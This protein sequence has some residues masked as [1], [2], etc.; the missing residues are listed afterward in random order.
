[1]K[2]INKIKIKKKQK[3]ARRTRA[4]IFGIATRPRLCVF[5]SNKHIYVQLIND[6]KGIT[7]A[8]ASD[9]EVAAKGKKQRKELAKMVGQQIAQKAQKLKIK[10]AIF[11]K[12]GY[13]YHGL[14]K[15][16]AEGAREEGLEF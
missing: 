1:M 10:K 13:K 7:L 12:G 9:F 11:D 14:I 6:E 16:L 3:R 15:N 2:D 5:R 4:K 8:S